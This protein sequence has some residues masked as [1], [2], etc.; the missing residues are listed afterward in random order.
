MDVL[1]NRLPP[2]SEDLPAGPDLRK[3]Y[4]PES[5]YYRLRDARAEARSAERQADSGVGERSKDEPTL[6]ERWR[7]VRDLAAQALG[8]TRDLEI[9]AWHVEALL[10]CDKLAG[11]SV[12]VDLLAAMIGELWDSVHPLPDSD[13]TSA[14]LAS[15]TGLNGQ[16]GD[17]TLM[18]PL[19]KLQ[20]FKRA[21]GGKVLLWQYK[22]SKD[23]EGLGDATQ[24]QQR[25]DGGVLPFDVM[26]AAARAAGS[27]DLA[28]LRENAATALAAWDRLAAALHA[29]A[30]DDDPPTGSVRD[31]LA[32]L[33][34]IADAYAGSAAPSAPEAAAPELVNTDPFPLMATEP[35]PAVFSA[36]PPRTREDALRA[37]QGIAEFF[38][39]TEPLS[40]LS[41]TLQDA[42]R[43]GRMT[44][45]ELLAEIVPDWTERKNIL[46][47]LGIKAP[48]PE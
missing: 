18:Q 40:P 12:G 32:E 6:P 29:V 17:G 43:R 24:R 42:V 27:G 16:G 35:G 44:W 25:I 30:G 15:I 13:G 26:E 41:Y 23:V 22:Q 46:T 45:P 36:A 7:L 48:D 34:A 14:R 4:T 38:L 47:N 37:L 20:L 2:V 28:V 21:D 5:L 19:R 9:G 33:H 1:P 11:F 31:V 39:R 8:G 10:R 3:D